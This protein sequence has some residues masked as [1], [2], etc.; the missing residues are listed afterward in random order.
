MEDVLKQILDKLNSLEQGQE[1][2][3]K[4]VAFLKQDQQEMRNDITE[5]KQGQSKLEQYLV[6]IE[7]NHGEKLSALF[8]ARE[9]QTDVNEK[10]LSTLGRIEAK[11]DVLQMETAHIR[12][13]K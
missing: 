2:L 4:D 8:D 3:S 6:R 11:V 7:Q 1:R 12:R 10:I 5:L 9:V 13:I